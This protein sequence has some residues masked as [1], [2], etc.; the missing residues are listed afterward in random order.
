MLKPRVN[1]VIDGP[2]IQ[3]EIGLWIAVDELSGEATTFDPCG[4][5]DLTVP[6]HIDDVHEGIALWVVHIKIN[7]LPL[8]NVLGDGERQSILIPM[9]TAN[10]NIFQ[11]S[12]DA[13]STATVKS[14][15]EYL[16]IR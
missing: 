4:L 7:F 3:D 2:S 14:Q 13:A 6:W 8:R 15:N 16:L 9:D 1:P 5:V 11:C 12:R 10:P